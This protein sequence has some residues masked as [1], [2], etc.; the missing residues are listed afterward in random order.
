MSATTTEA[1][2]PTRFPGYAQP[3]APEIDASCSRPLL[4]LITCSVCWLAVS[5]LVSL[6]ASIKLHGPGFLGQSASLSYGRL[7]AAASST[8]LYGFASQAG[9][10]IA[11]WL[12][13]R[14]GKTFLIWPGGVIVGGLLWNLTTFIGFCG[15]L[16]GG[17]TAIPAFEMPI[18]TWPMFLTAYFIFGLSG[19]LTF[20][21]R[22]ETE[23]YPSIW[24]LL[25]AF[26]VFPWVY[27]TAGFLL[28]RYHLRAPMQPI[29]GIWFANN[30]QALW[31]GSIALAVIFY[32]VSKLAQ[33]PLYSHGLAAF[34]FWFYL[35]GA[36]A[37][38]FQNMAAVPAWLSALS[39][40]ANII[41]LVPAFAIVVNWF[42][43]W[44]HHGAKNKKADPASG[45]VLVAAYSFLGYAI[46][47]AVASL[48]EVDRFLG[49]T[50]F[51]AGVAQ[52]ALYG[53]I[54]MAFLGAIAHIFPRLADVDWPRP[55]FN[56][57]HY[58][59]SLLGIVLTVAGLLVAGYIQAEGLSSASTPFITV[60]RHMMAPTGLVTI[61]F[62]FL[63]FAQLLLLCN[64]ATILK[65]CCP[66]CG[67]RKTEVA[68]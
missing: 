5:L 27:S 24:F 42:Y 21:S 48:R 40:V 67:T 13:A 30:F 28:G 19:L 41:L 10:A 11:L 2:A 35:L 15:I 50:L 44:N 16:C 52:L 55:K 6:I 58:T 66:C 54:T 1:P 3:P 34:G 9:I 51:P 31:L 36:T 8:F 43:T 46:L 49:L 45:Y 4:F 26:F 53:F 37:G 32:F 56:S 17:T 59:L 61:G 29:V 62:L 22:T 39:A 38:G 60:F 18:L 68:R 12:M 57:M 20:I 25:A 64:I 23:L 47:N 65:Y 14:L 63:F 7:V 33:Y